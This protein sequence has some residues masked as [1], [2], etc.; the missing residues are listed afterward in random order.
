MGPGP[1]SLAGAVPRPGCWYRTG[2]AGLEPGRDTQLPHCDGHIPPRQVGHA[3]GWDARQRG[4]GFHR[5]C[6]S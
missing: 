5:G 3:T 6:N 2:S 4:L 1:Q